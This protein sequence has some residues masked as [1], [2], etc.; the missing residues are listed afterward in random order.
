VNGRVPLVVSTGHTGTDTAVENSKAAE[1]LGAD[2]LMNLPPY[3]MKTNADGIFH[4]F[5]S[6]S[7]AVSIPIMVQDAPL[8][9]QVPL[10]PPL[11]A[12]VAREIEHVEYVKV[13]APPT[14]PKISAILEAGDDAVLFGGLNGLFFIE[15]YQRGSSGIMPN[16]DM[17]PQ[18]V[19][20]WNHLESGGKQQAWERFVHILP[21]I[22]LQ[23]Q[24]GL[25]V[26]AATHNMV[27]R[28]VINSAQ[29]RHPTSALDAQGLSELDALRRWVEAGQ[30]REA[31]CAP[32]ES[33]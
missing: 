14:A 22:R 31:N 7:K 28:G 18:Y 11:L 23:L 19:E 12:R 1:D 10:P 2:A 21:L 13:E 26:S 20:I 30:V 9:T 4:Y 16:C 33:A 29:V 32:V 3:Y 25:G 24:P 6:I 27:A 5:E 17:I 8:M 15:E